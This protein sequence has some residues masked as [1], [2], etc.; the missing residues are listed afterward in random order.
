MLT[1]IGV[2]A[3]AAHPA[4]DRRQAQCG[5][6]RQPADAGGGGRLRRIGAESRPSS[7]QEFAAFLAAEREKWR[8]VVRLSGIKIE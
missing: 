4:G 3:P 5:D 7:P 8:E 1:Y 6:E 2:V